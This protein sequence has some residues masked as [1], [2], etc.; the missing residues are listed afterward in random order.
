M[1]NVLTGSWK[2]ALRRERLTSP[3]KDNELRHPRQSPLDKLKNIAAYAFTHVCMAV[4]IVICFVP[5]F[6]LR[7]LMRIGCDLLAFEGQ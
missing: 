7:R 4:W 5:L 6:K 1:E 2:R 3:A